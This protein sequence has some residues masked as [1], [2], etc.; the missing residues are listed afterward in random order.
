MTVS[1][2]GDVA[3]SGESGPV[4]RDD[5]PRAGVPVGGATASGP[6]RRRP[7]GVRA[8]QIVAAQAAVALL[9]AAAGRGPLVMVAAGLGAAV[10]VLT[11]WLRLRRRWL[12]EWIRIGVRY[13]LRRHALAPTAEPAAL[14]DLLLPGAR[15]DPAELGGDAAAVIVDG[16]GLTAVLELGDPTGL[17]A[18]TPLSLPNPASLLPAAGAQTPPIRIQ[19]VLTGAPAPTLRAGGGTPA[20]SY[21]QLTDGRLLGHERALLAIRVLR[22]EGFT[23]ADLRRALSSTVR[24]V[25][26]RL[27]PV[28]A[29]PLGD[30]AAL[31]VLGELAHHDGASP[32]QESWQA[33]RLGGL[34]Q[35]TF[36]LRRWPDARSETARRLVPRLLALPATATTV[37][38]S[39]G[40]RVGAATDPLPLDLTV[41]LAAE[42]AAGLSTAMQAMRRLL[43]AENAT[44]RRL[45][46]EHLDGFAATLP[47][48][49]A[50]TGPPAQS[51]NALMDVLELPFGTAGLMIGANRHGAAV[52]VRLFRAEATRVMLIGGVAAAQLVALRA[53]AL[54]A[55]VVVQTARPRAWE[56]FVRAVSAP[57]ET[58]PLVP[59]GRQVGGPAGTPL[60]PLLVVVD[61]G[62][63]TADAQPGPG[64]QA[65]LVVRDE[66]TPADTDA[67]SRADLVVLQ[68]LRPD[69]AALAGVALGLGDSAEWLTRIRGD[70]VGVIN[71]RALRWALLSAT[72]IEVQLIGPPTRS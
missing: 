6:V 22:A 10:L 59:P 42:N 63:V 27:A 36:R 20:T 39:A 1:V 35:T 30:R 56:P 68:P 45:D 15:V 24:K 50:Q 14:L 12:F 8:G 57:G 43:A 23:E 16:Y 19:L 25:R 29:R 26:R 21:R 64:W 62:P 4:G 52:T 53:M 58:I 65:N 44:G 69:E 55:R 38:V 32:A 70:M 48:G 51:P 7:F 31:G 5:D 33:V 61:V 54:G 71:R 41:R 28:P 34:L 49:T 37:S 9:L 17:L 40:P 67:V 3:R 46:G 11:A 18:D 2:A 13:A 66:L 72:P 47:L 60:H